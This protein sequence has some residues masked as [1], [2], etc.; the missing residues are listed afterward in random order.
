MANKKNR[1]FQSQAEGIQPLQLVQKSTRRPGSAE[2]TRGEITFL[3][4]NK[5]CHEKLVLKLIDYLKDL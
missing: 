5:E 3:D 1:T 4:G 2:H